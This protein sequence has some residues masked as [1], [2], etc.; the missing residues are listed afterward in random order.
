MLNSKRLFPCQRTVR[1]PGNTARWLWHRGGFLVGFLLL[2]QQRYNFC[3]LLRSP[4][5]MLVSILVIVMFEELDILRVP[6]SRGSALVIVLS[7]NSLIHLLYHVH[8]LVLDIFLKTS[9]EPSY[10]SLSSVFLN[11][12]VVLGLI[13]T[14]PLNLMLR[15][16]VV[17]W[18]LSVDYFSLHKN[19]LVLFN[20]PQPSPLCGNPFQDSWECFHWR[21]FYPLKF[22]IKNYIY[23]IL[24][25]EIK[26]K[27]NALL[28]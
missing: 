7:L 16:L 22:K 12:G 24:C 25:A 13:G 1:S 18:A 8:H 6:L 21:F 27:F 23:I 28:I 14:Q 5:G 2:P 9:I 10:D 26:V 20:Q 19:V 15:F 17:I 4:V 3:D 11:L